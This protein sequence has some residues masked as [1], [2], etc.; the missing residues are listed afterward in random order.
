MKSNAYYDDWI[1]MFPLILDDDD[2]QRLKIVHERWTNFDLYIEDVK[3][4][5]RQIIN[6]D[7][8]FLKN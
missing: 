4:K 6:S 5:V 8:V 2:I 7:Y 3:T 1:N